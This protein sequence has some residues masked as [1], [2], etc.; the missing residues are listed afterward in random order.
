MEIRA[1]ICGSA[2]EARKL[3]QRSSTQIKVI[4]DTEGLLIDQLDLRDKGGNPFSGED[5]ARSAQVIV[6]QDGKLLWTNYSN[7]YRV[8]MNAEEILS[9]T[10]KVLS[11]VSASP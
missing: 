6:S 7:N 11:S 9:I 1:V 2:D 10:K 3:E 5:V 8:R 4:A